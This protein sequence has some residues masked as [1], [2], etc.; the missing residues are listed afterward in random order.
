MSRGN[1]KLWQS[2]PLSRIGWTALLVA[3][4]CAV[5]ARAGTATVFPGVGA[6]VFF[7]PY[8]V[9]ATALILSPMRQGWVYILARQRGDRFIRPAGGL[10]SRRRA[11]AGWPGGSMVRHAP[12][13]RRDA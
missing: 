12:R 3:A 1:S 13:G 11:C 8:A 2:S 7:P 5:G 4:G 6:A 9:L 10:W